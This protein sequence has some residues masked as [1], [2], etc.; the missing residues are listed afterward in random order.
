MAQRKPYWLKVRLPSSLQF[1]RVKGILRQLKLHSVCEEALCPNITECFH[2]GTATFL[3]LGNTCTRG[4]RYCH[5]TPGR[6]QAVDEKE[7]ERLVEAVKTLGLQ[8]VVITSVTRDDLPE[9]GAEIFAR[10]VESLHCE[11]PDCKVEVLVPDF[12]GNREALERIIYARPDV[13]NHNMEVVPALFRDLRPHGHYEVSLELLHR[14]HQH[15]VVTKSGFMVGFGE[16]QRD[17]LRLLRDLS[18]VNCECLTVGQYQQ[19]TRNHWPVKKYYSLGE[20]EEIKKMAYEMGFRYVESSPLVRS[21]Y[22]AA[23]AGQRARGDED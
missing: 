10:S 13:I 7:P 17:I 8:Y 9:G 2:S 6:P 14:V 19:P 20:F 3:I 1:K 18:L 5:I 12:Q 16:K 23:Y 22:R 15:N 4:C 21:S 11:I